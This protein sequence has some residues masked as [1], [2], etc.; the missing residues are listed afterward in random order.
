M[1]VTIN[2]DIVLGRVHLSTT[3]PITKE[4][5][6]DFIADVLVF[7]EEELG[8]TIGELSGDAGSKTIDVNKTYSALIK[9]LSGLYCLAH[10]TG[11]SCAGRDC[12]IGALNPEAIA[13]GVSPNFLQAQVDRDI[14]RKKPIAFIVGEDTTAIAEA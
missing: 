2:A 13:R 14:D 4:Q 9:N 10:V 3:D 5:V 7:V 6:E 8:V 12:Q 11:G 1:V